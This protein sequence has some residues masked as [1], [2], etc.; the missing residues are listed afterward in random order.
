VALLSD[1]SYEVAIYAAADPTQSRPSQDRAMAS[2]DSDH[3]LLAVADGAG[4]HKSGGRAAS[5]TV[6]A[7]EQATSEASH[8]GREPRF[9]ILDALER[10]NRKV[11]ALG[12]GA[13]T[14][15]ASALVVDNRV[16]TFHVGDAMVLVVGGR[17]RVRLITAPHSPVGYAVEAGVI[18]PEEAMHHEDR[19]LVSN[20]VGDVDMRVEIRTPM[21]LRPRDTVVV[22]SDG[23]YDNM[24]SDE[25][26]DCLRRH[27]HLSD[28]AEA[29]AEACHQRMVSPRK[30]EPSKPDDLAFVLLR[31]QRS[32]RRK[33]DPES[34]NAN[35][36]DLTS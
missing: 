31:S 22:G 5:I 15:L 26:G 2:L 10:A 6:H 30:G 8:D 9:A 29:L 36:Q 3:V 24:H 32:S 4:G 33:T 17:G 1:D 25:I 12:D 35:S 13:A 14:T 34:P 19:H 20:V 28:A 21:G 27:R 18:E 23:L 7:L 11:I 16:R